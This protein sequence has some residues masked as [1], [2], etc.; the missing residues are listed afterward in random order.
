MATLAW[1]RGEGRAAVA[2]HDAVRSLLSAEITTDRCDA[3]V[4]A[5]DRTS[6]PISTAEMISKVPNEDLRTALEE[7]QG[8][9]HAVVSATLQGRQPDPDMG[10]DQLRVVADAVTALIRRLEEL[11]R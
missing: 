9:F 10:V 1:I 2:A 11:A 6:T 3:A 4:D 8:R 7:E 5:L